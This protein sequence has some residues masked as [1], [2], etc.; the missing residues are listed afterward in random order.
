M[1]YLIYTSF[2]TPSLFNLILVSVLALVLT[3]LLGLPIIQW[4]QHSNFLDQIHKEH[5][6]ELEILHKNKAR[7]PTG[8]G[9]LL[10]V[11][12]L[13]SIFIWFSWHS[14]VT[15]IIVILA[16]CWCALGWYDDNIKNKKRKGHGLKAKHKFLVQ[17]LIAVATLVV[18]PKIYGSTQPLFLLRIPFVSESIYMHSVFGKIF[19]LGLALVAIVGTCN[20]VNLTDGLDGL[21]AGTFS[22]AALGLLIVAM[23]SPM[24]PKISQEIVYALAILV[25][26]SV[27]FLW[28]NGFPAQIFMGDTGSLL[29]GGMLGSFA[30]ILRAELFLIIIG[31]VFVLEAGSVILQIVHY[32]WRKKRIFLCSPLHHHYEYKGIPESKIVL[33]FWLFGIICAGIGVLSVFWR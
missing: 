4:L 8:G 2:K 27:G 26:M 11:V 7:V 28:Y 19:C 10:F 18:L 22:F 20:A 3:I 5:C 29:L 16:F 1:I 25:G 17:M 24:L 6:K 33:R 13:I 32:R 21:A 14:L 15:W 12:F 23:H 9:V 31:G 30:V